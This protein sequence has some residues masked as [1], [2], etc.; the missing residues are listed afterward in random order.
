MKRKKFFSRR[1]GRGA[2]TEDALETRQE[3]QL[4]G[5]PPAGQVLLRPGSIGQRIGAANSHVE[6]ALGD[7]V[8]YLARPPPQFL[9]VR[10][11]VHQRRPGEEQ[12]SAAVQPMRVERRDLVPRG[13]VAV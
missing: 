4:A 10:D 5:S 9:D 13:A 11:V 6:L 12:R 8:E 7:P 3:Q 1:T 2:C